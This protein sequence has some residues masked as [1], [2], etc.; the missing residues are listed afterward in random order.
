MESGVADLATVRTT[1]LSAEDPKVLRYDSCFGAQQSGSK[2]GR[3][4]TEIHRP[5]W[6]FYQK[7]A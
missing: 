6:S 7:S 1:R 3:L 5:G 4:P 2:F